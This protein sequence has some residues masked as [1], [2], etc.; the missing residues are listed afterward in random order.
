MADPRVPGQRSAL[1]GGGYTPLITQS[2]LMRQQMASGK[3]ASEAPQSLRTHLCLQ[4][5][6]G[7]APLSPRLARRIGLVNHHRSE[8][9]N[10]MVFGAHVIVYSKDATADRAFFRD[11]LGFLSVDAG[12]G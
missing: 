6:T 2:T 9:S 1:H 10:S 8:R 3:R 4:I 11:V 5:N 12:V 7:T